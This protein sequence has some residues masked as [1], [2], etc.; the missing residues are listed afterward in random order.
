M[1][2]NGEQAIDMGLLDGIRTSSSY[3]QHRQVMHL[4][5]NFLT[6]SIVILMLLL[7]D[8]A[9]VVIDILFMVLCYCLQVHNEQDIQEHVSAKCKSSWH[10]A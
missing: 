6:W 2:F 5:Q 1:L 3:S 7:V 8:M 9:D 4:L 10:A